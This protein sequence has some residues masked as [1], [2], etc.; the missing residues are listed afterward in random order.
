MIQPIT[1][2]EILNGLGQ[3]YYCYM[4]GLNEH[5]YKCDMWPSL[6]DEVGG[7]G[8]L[9]RDGEE[10]VG[11][12][13]FIPKKHAR[14]IAIPTSPDNERLEATMVISCLHVIKDYGGRG[15]A[16]EM[17]PRLIASCRDRGYSRIEA[18][19][20]PGTPEEAGIN[21]SFYPFRKFGFTVDDSR[22]GWEFRPEI[23]ICSLELREGGE[24]PDAPDK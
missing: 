23:R 19:V 2:N 5:S 15:I 22:E 24:P 11:Q 12:M 6:F 13:I 8:F 1:R 17:I 3:D 4:F 21:T 20:H 9:A 18:C 10:V 16:S 14:R 7:I